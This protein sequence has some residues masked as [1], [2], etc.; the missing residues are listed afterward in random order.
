VVKALKVSGT[1]LGAAF[2]VTVTEADKDT[3]AIVG[4]ANDAPLDLRVTFNDEHLSVSGEAL[5]YECNVEGGP[6]D[7]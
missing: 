5:G 3:L 1:I 6:H 4:T 7:A 2:T